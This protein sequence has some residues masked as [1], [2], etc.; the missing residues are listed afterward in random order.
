VGSHGGSE[1]DESDVAKEI[2]KLGMTIIG[3]EAPLQ[4]F[5][6]AI[7]Q[8]MAALGVKQ[9]GQFKPPSRYTKH[10]AGMLFCARL[11]VWDESRRGD[12]S[13]ANERLKSLC[14]KWLVDDKITPV[15]EVYTLLTRGLT[16]I[17]IENLESEVRLSDC[18]TK[19]WVNGGQDKG[20]NK[21]R[22][23][24]IK[25]MPTKL[26][27]EAEDIIKS[28]LFRKDDGTLPTK[29]EMSQFHENLHGCGQVKPLF[30]RHH[31][32]EESYLEVV[33]AID[34]DKELRAQ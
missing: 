11:T 31:G 26:L 27:A 7:T 22:V 12:P 28:L 9:D 18:G 33:E 10:L 2:S 19:F 6:F 13:G 25:E 3:Q 30:L 16:I 23:D 29:S 24:D 4:H 17:K 1:S 8:Y 15:A 20:C 14:S 5:E 21:I 32:L 34:T